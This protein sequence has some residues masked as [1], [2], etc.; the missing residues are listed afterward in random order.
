MF[1]MAHGAGAGMR[2][3]FME[4]IAEA[5][6]AERIATTRFEFPYMAAGK[7][8]IDA[9]PV[10]EQTLRDAV[11]AARGDLPLFAGGK[12]FGGRMSSH[13]DLDVRG[14]IF[15]GFPLHPANKPATE[16]GKHLAGVRVPMLFLQGTRDALCDLRR[17]RP[18]L[19]KLPRATLHVVRG[20]DHGF[21]VRK[22][23]RRDVIAELATAIRRFCVENSESSGAASASGATP[24]NLLRELLPVSPHG[25]R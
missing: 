14:L 13:L 7:K 20:A 12:S 10:I 22:Q 15:L 2:H 5:L 19:R 18:L 23:D 11:E 9:R 6:F 8:R 21:A 1:V 17:L 25:S 4:S 24:S 16:R 3:P